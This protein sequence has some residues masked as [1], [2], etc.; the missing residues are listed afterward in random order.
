MKKTRQQT[1][2]WIIWEK[3]VSDLPT[4]IQSA[5]EQLAIYYVDHTDNDLIL[6]S[7]IISTE[8][9][10]PEDVARVHEVYDALFALDLGFKM[11]LF[12]TPAEWAL[13][14]NFY[15][16]RKWRVVRYATLLQQGNWCRCCGARP[17]QAELHV[18]HIVPRSIDPSKA[19]DLL[20]TQVLCRDCNL[21]KGNGDSRDW[22]QPHTAETPQQ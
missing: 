3:V 6:G 2:E 9:V 18:D 12:R 15:T 19:W 1:P 5:C 22:R 8:D 21:G 20:N 7:T 13:D 14:R 10:A 16:G 17:P 4:N 11:I